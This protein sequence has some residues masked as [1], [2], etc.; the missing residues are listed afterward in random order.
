MPQRVNDECLDVILRKART[1]NGYLPEPVTDDELRRIYELT[2]VG[3]TSANS[4][5]ARFVFVRTPEAKAR[6]LP[7]LSAGN[8]EKTKQAPVTVIL[9]YDTKFWELL[10]T[11]L[12]T[13]RPEMKDPYE[14]SP[15]LSE[16]VAF[17]NSSLQGA[18]FMIAAR[19]LG[20]DVGGM[21]GFDN[22]KVDDEFFPDGRVKSNFLI[23]VGHGDP[24]K[25]MPKLPRLSFEEA[26][27]VL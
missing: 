27:T 13:H 4:S 19:A 20:L 18:Y 7:A 24:A 22:K 12:F 15:T 9:G 5:P 3:S 23:N 17:R 10:P 2:A 8:Q 16:T 21:S 1:Q 25:V 14:K 6:L 26:C 11:K